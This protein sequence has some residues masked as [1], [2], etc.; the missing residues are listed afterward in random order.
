MNPVVNPMPG[1]AHFEFHVSRKAREKYRFDESLFALN[2]NIILADY[3]AARRF[4]DSMTRVRGKFV[5]ASAINAMG[6]IDEILH[7]LIHQYEKQNPGV[8][9]R[10]LQAAGVDADAALL[11]FTEDFP[12]LAVFRG[13][14]E[15]AKYLGLET[16]NRQKRAGAL[17]EMLILHI[18]NQNPAVTEYKELFDEEP[19]KLSSP[20]EKTVRVL[21]DFLMPS[22]PLEPGRQ[23]VKAGRH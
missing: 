15:A 13:E 10:A 6:L 23:R 5:P 16:S 22:L 12:P 20:Y 19:L 1:Q 14:V 21:K 9:E 18:T 3:A 8:M 11:K 4:A 7:I 2:G 17:E